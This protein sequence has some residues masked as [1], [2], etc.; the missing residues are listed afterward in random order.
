MRRLCKMGRIL[1][2][3]ADDML[4]QFEVNTNQKYP[5]A[6][7]TD[8]IA[9]LP[10]EFVL[11]EQIHVL[12]M[13]LIIN[14][15]NYLDKLTIQPTEFYEMNRIGNRSASSSQPSLKAIEN[16]F[17]YLETRYQEII[18]VTVASALSGT[19]SSIKEGAKKFQKK[20]PR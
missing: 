17:S 2:Q 6:L 15:V 5:I 14:D 20:E 7:V 11:K 13:N 3:K 4:L 8:S 9:D 18:V 1:Q 19:Y 12:P 16:L 10:A